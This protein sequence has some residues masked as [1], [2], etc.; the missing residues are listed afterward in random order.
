MAW[1]DRTPFEAIDNEYRSKLAIE[2]LDKIGVPVRRWSS[3]F[4]GNGS[5]ASHM[6]GKPS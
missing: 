6:I 5:L 1:E 4:I 2:V 3:D